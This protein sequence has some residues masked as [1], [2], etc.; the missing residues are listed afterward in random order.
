M[1][2]WKKRRGM[3]VSGGLGEKE[4]IHDRARSFGHHNVPKAFL[5]SLSFLTSLLGETERK[6]LIGRQG[7][8]RKIWVRSFM[9]WL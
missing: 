1:L 5:P 6:T 3:G 2:R 4:E 9:L 7:K 8:E